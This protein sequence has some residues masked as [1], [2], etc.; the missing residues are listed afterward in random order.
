MIQEEELMQKS[1]RIYE[2]GIKL[3]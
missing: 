2:V 1:M 3:V